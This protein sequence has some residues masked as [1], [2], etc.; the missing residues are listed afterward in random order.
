MPTSGANKVAGPSGGPGG[1][2]VLRG[3]GAC[4]GLGKYFRLPLATC[5]FDLAARVSSPRNRALVAAVAKQQRILSL[6]GPL[7]LAKRPVDVEAL[8][9]DL[10][11]DPA[12]RE[13]M[14]GNF[15]QSIAGLL[16]SPEALRRLCAAQAKPSSRGFPGSSWKSRR[17]RRML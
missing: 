3:R 10:L 1:M 4:L 15:A 6:A 5:H 11:A 8:L 16:A 9:A 2:R 13:R 14:A 17:R 12:E 7:D